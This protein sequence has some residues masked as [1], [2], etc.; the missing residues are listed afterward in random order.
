MDIIL[1]KAKIPDIGPGALLYMWFFFFNN[2]KQLYLIKDNK[3][4]TAVFCSKWLN[5]ITVLLQVYLTTKPSRGCRTHSTRGNASQDAAAWLLPYRCDFGKKYLSFQIL[6]F[7]TLINPWQ[8]GH[9]GLPT[10]NV[11]HASVPFPHRWVLKLAKSWF[12]K[13]GMFH[14]SIF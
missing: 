12:I 9:A 1:L 8:W 11:G 4:F 13:R 10:S 3:L 2:P 6:I 14:G 5:G 7:L